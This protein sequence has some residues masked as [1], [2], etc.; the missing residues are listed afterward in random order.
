MDKDANMI[1]FSRRTPNSSRRA[2]TMIEL[3]AVGAILAILSLILI[4]IL[5]SRV[6]DAR[7][8][9]A[10]D[11]LSQL[12]KIVALGYADTNFY[13]RLQ[14]YENNDRYS[15]AGDDPISTLPFYRYYG[16]AYPAYPILADR[17]N[18][19]ND[20]W[21]GPYTTFQN[22]MMMNELA[23]ARPYAVTD[24]DSDPTGNGPIFYFSATEEL[25]LYPL[26][27]WGNPYLFFPTTETLFRNGRVET[28][29]RPAIYSMGSDGMPGA[30]PVITNT[31]DYLPSGG[32]L[33]EGDDLVWRL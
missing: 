3:V 15:G 14:D 25:D 27:P 29:Y 6:E 26:D 9:A 20:R 21:K 8:K 31:D 4:P 22:A 19:A 24:L 32:A 33:G 10:M 23:L 28:S 11:E 7:K 17:A 16:G 5:H 2:V 12:G 18:L 13:F 1:Y 30:L